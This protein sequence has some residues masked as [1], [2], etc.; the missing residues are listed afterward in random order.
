M[1]QSGREGRTPLHFASCGHP[2]TV[3]LLLADPRNAVDNDG[4]TPLY[5]VADRG[6]PS[7]V[8]L[9]LAVPGIDINKANN[10]G[11]TALACN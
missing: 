1:N 3:E 4:G 7:V 11:K 2:S 6:H 10:D 8:K 5:L 9:L